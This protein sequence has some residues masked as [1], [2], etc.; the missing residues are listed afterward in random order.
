MYWSSTS[1][2]SRAKS[3]ASSAGW[4][5]VCA[6]DEQAQVRAVADTRGSHEEAKLFLSRSL[7][8][9][10]LLCVGSAPSHS[11]P[12]PPPNPPSLVGS[13]ITELFALN[14]QFHHAASHFQR[15]SIHLFEP[16]CQRNCL[17]CKFHRVLLSYLAKSQVRPL[18]PELA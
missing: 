7:R 12:S 14:Q 10:L 5:Q 3:V 16:L 9:S 17:V 18:H 4:R 13:C 6:H 2:N 8:L 1:S 15:R 11:A